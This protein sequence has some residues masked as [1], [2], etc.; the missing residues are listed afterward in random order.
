MFYLKW[1]IMGKGFCFEAIAEV[2]IYKFAPWDLPDRP[3]SRSC[4]LKWYFFCPVEK[5]KYSNGAIMNCATEVGYWKI[6]G[7]DRPVHHNEE[8]VGLIK[9]SIFHS[10]K[11]PQGEQTNWVMRKYGLEDKNMANKG[12]I[13]NT[14]VLCMIFQKDGLGPRNGAQYGTPFKEEDWNDDNEVNCVEAGPTLCFSTP[15]CVLL[16]T[17]TVW[18]SRVPFFGWHIF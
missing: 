7:K 5:N 9:T 8:L 12:V 17:V 2:D 4:D 15:T 11:A 6:I 3:S 14:H 16:L 18:L 1:K 13:Q 10:G